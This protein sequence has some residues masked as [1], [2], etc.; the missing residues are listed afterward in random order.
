MNTFEYLKKLHNP[1]FFNNLFVNSILYACGI[2]IDVIKSEIDSLKKEMFIITC[3]SNL[4]KFESDFKIPTDLSKSYDDRR[5]GIISKFTLNRNISFESLKNLI[6]TF[7][8]DVVILKN[9]TNLCKDF[10]YFTLHKNVLKFDSNY[11]QLKSKN[12][13]EESYFQCNVV[14]NTNYFCSLEMSEITGYCD[15]LWLDTN[16]IELQR[17]RITGATGYIQNDFTS[18]SKARKAKIILGNN[19]I[20]THNFKRILFKEGSYEEYIKNANYITIRFLNRKDTIFNTSDMETSLKIVKPAHIQIKYEYN[21]FK[22]GDFSTVGNLNKIKLNE[23][24]G[25]VNVG[26]NHR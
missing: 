16:S 7:N 4:T 12:L 11:V 9:F 21:F 17:E 20:G 18:P 22:V 8:K 6:F 1:R 10:N 15:I 23:F 13:N 14:P 19:A 24:S 2:N 5:A 25:G 3:E 26:K